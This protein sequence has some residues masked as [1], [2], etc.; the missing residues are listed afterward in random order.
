LKIEPFL[1][2]CGERIGARDLLSLTLD[3]RIN[4]SSDK[5]ARFIAPLARNF[6]R[7]VGIRAQRQ[8]FLCSRDPILS[9]QQRAPLGVTS[10]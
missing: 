6:Q 5:L 8:D 1:R 7:H 9:R 4:T 3:A 2:D 10:K